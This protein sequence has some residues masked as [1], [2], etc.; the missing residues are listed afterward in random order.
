[1]LT[2]VCQYKCIQLKNITQ[3]ALVGHYDCAKQ[4]Q[5]QGF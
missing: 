3:A 1:M 2:N 5:Y 4:L